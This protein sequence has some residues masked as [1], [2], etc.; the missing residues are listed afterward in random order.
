MI[1][2]L[3]VLIF[4]KTCQITWLLHLCG[5]SSRA[6]NRLFDK[7]D[8]R[9]RQCFLVNL[10]KNR[11]DNILDVWTH[12]NTWSFKKEIPIC[13]SKFILASLELLDSLHSDLVRRQH[14]YKLPDLVQN[15]RFKRQLTQTFLLQHPR[16]I[17]KV[18][19]SL[20]DQFSWHILS[21]KEGFIKHLAVIFEVRSNVVIF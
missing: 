15:R 9:F 4:F 16:E 18:E 21:F 8:Q 14:A 10:L 13:V 17:I 20:G 6:S 2:I 12:F 11:K 7:L 3:V 19:L 1:W 5:D